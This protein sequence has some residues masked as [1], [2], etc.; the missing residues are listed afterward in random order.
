MSFQQNITNPQGCQLGPRAHGLFLCGLFLCGFLH[1]QTALLTSAGS[2]WVRRSVSTAPGLAGGTRE[3]RRSEERRQGDREQGWSALRSCT[4]SAWL[5]LWRAAP[6]CHGWSRGREGMKRESLRGQ[7]ASPGQGGGGDFE[8]SL[9]FVSALF[10]ISCP[11]G[12]SE[13][14]PGF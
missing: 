3:S 14:L 12:A 2:P 13:D 10:L 9:R 4:C 1:P 8:L 6:V 5:F 7:A 11:F